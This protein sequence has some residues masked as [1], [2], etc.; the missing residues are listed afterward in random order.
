VSLAKLAQKVRELDPF[1]A[2]RGGR[3]RSTSLV[4][5]SEPRQDLRSNCKQ[6][7]GWLEAHSPI[8]ALLVEFFHLTVLRSPM[9]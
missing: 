2:W 1:R 6:K 3:P 7:I 5:F 8:S 4:I 9:T